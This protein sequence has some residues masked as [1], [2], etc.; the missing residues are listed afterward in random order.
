MSREGERIKGLT[1]A[2]TVWVMAAVGITCGAGM[3]V[4]AAVATALVLIVLAVFRIVEQLILPREQANTRQHIKVETEAVT[5]QLIA[6]IYE[7]CAASHITIEKLGIN[8]EPGET[9][10][11]MLC[12][13]DS[14]SELGKA[15]GALHGLAGVRAVHAK[16]RSQTIELAAHVNRERKGR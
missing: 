13:A 5:G 4:E 3:L 12:Q 2:A 7:T 10:I 14:A 8:T 11:E 6:D 1:T 9:S 15:I 16:S